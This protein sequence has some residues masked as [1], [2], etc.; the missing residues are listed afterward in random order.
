MGELHFETTDQGHLPAGADVTAVLAAGGDVALSAVWSTYNY[1]QFLRGLIDNAGR[2]DT[3][4]ERQRSASELPMLRAEIDALAEVTALQALEANRRLTELL[5]GRRWMVMRD[6]REAGESWTTIG[7]ALG[8]SK[9]GALDWY[10]R[11]IAN[12]ENSMLHDADRAR[13]VVTE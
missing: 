12:Q 11:K 1:R 8:M 13:A 6:A 3:D 9:Q 7:T 4:A 2:G 10:K 5:V